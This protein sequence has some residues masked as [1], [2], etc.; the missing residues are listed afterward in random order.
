MLT[1]VGELL[2]CAWPFTFRSH[3]LGIIFDY[4]V[5]GLLYD[6]HSLYFPL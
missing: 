2:A 5:T 4:N 3:S 1:F 6:F